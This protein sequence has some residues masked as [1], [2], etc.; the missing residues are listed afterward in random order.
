MNDYASAV[1]DYNT[2]IA[3]D[4]DDVEMFYNRGNA[5]FEMK[6]F[7]GAIEDYNKVIFINPKDAESYYNRAISKYNLGERESACND[8]SMAL[9]Y[10]DKVAGDV[11]RELCH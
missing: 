5:K 7:K 6:D 9:K 11:M 4:S 10:G 2:A 8:L 1:E 3:A